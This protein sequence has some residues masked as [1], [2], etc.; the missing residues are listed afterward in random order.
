MIAVQPHAQGAILPVRARPGAKADALLDEFD[1][2]LRVSVTAPP[3]RGR[4]NEA[5]VVVLSEALNL[6]RSQITLLSGETSRSKRFL[7]RGLSPEDLLARIDAALT[8]TIYEPPDP[9]V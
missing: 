5:I 8:P 2:A 1:G 4:A 7:I 6:R 9:E 3:D